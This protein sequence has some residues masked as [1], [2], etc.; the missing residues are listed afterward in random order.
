MTRVILRTM[1]TAIS[2]PDDLFIEADRLARRLGISRSQLYARAANDFLKKHDRAD[3]TERLN[4]VFEKQGAPGVDPV[5][6][7]LQ[8]ASVPR[9]DW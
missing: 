8:A 3:V 9:E 7:R 6:S 1:K 2:I 5:L 4:R